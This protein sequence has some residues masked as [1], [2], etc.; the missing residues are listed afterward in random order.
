MKLGSTINL[1]ILFQALCLIFSSVTPVGAQVQVWGTS[2]SG[3]E[4]E[5]GS[6]YSVFEDGSEFTIKSS[7]NKS[8]D[9]TNPR[10]TVTIASDGS[11]YGISSAGGANNAGTIFRY[12]EGEF[13]VLHQLDFNI[14]GGNASTDLVW[15]DPLTF[16]GATLNGGANGGGVLFEYSLISGLTILHNFEGSSG[17]NSRGGLAIDGDII[18][19]TCSNG[20]LFGSG[21]VWSFNSGNYNVLHNFD[22]DDSGGN[23]EGGVILAND[24][25][26]YGTTRFGGSENQGT[27]FRIGVDGTNFETLHNL[28]LQ[29]PEGRFPRSRLVEASPGVFLGTCSD[30]GSSGA[31]VV[32]SI[33]SDGVYNVLKSLSSP[34]DGGFPK[35]GLSKEIDGRFYGVCE[36]GGA[37]GFGTLFSIE[38]DGNFTKIHDLEYVQDGANP[39]SSLAISGS[40]IYGVT[41]TGGANNF[42]TLIK[43]NENEQIEKLHDFSV[44]L[45]GSDPEGLVFHDGAF[46]GVS[47]DGGDF[48]EGIFYTIG[49]DGVRTK[50][51]DFDPVLEGRNPNGDIYYSDITDLF[52]GTFR[53]GGLTGFGAIFSIDAQGEIVILHS[54]Q[55][56]EQG[57]LPASSPY[58]HSNGSLF[59]TTRSGGS[60]GDG[61]L[62]S[63][64]TDGNYNVLHNFL[65]FFDG[66]KPGSRLV[67]GP[68]GNLYGLCSEGGGANGGSLFMYN[69][70]TNVLSVLHNFN[71]ALDGGNPI[72]A[73]LLH[74]DGKFYGTTQEGADGD[75]S[76]FSFSTSDGFE[77]LHSFDS[78]NDGSSAQG[79][80]QEGLDGSVFGICSEGGAN[81]SGTCFKYGGIDGFEV[82]HSFDSFD[83]PNPSGPIALFFP[84]CLE[85]GDCVSSDP[86][87]IGVCNFGICEE[88]P[89]NPAFNPLQIGVCEV[90]LDTYTLTLQVS[91]DLSPGGTFTIAD[92]TFNLIDGLTNY[93]FVLEGLPANGEPINL[94]YAFNET[95]CSGTT[96]VLGTA[97]PACPP[98]LTTF[99]VDVGD[100]EVS[101]EGIFLGGSF[102][103][104]TP[105]EIPMMDMGDGIWTVS[106]EVGSGTYEFNFFNGPAL[107]DAEY[108]IGECAD[109]GKRI[110]VVE[111]EPQTLEFCWGICGSN[112]S[113]GLFA[114]NRP[115]DQKILPYP[116]PI[117]VGGYLTIEV[118]DDFNA[119][120]FDVIS[121]NGTIIVQGSIQN[122]LFRIHTAGFRPGL[123]TVILR[124]ART[125]SI[126]RGRFIVN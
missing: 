122:T 83:N 44:P 28:D 18:Y 110:L 4:D 35:S 116:N 26:L 14:E 60:F 64:D 49:L 10:S 65:G 95:G 113:L 103:G 104:W 23:P 43:I 106:T 8:I 51:H 74:S 111:D 54:F 59:G 108:V 55:G 92:E 53:T 115:L 20:G 31:G 67:E 45:N 58:L 3:G 56:D 101:A 91:M 22:N 38:E 80:L 77:L 69:I 6:V 98:V 87:S 105:S 52:Y 12:S 118:P 70:Q 125:G 85:D 62:Y 37:N 102:Q 11:I 89:I 50:L 126:A 71:S 120:T 119:H 88:V 99:S 75:G 81:N 32:F 97:P 25:N 39:Q 41:V 109:N 24:G 124:E 79:N 27:I 15:I 40:S 96:G 29:T 61:L 123:Y 76:I 82:V 68:D 48:N 47:T 42:G 1:L 63:I 2:S 66:E 72:G 117:Q 7:F 112:C 90:G 114:S 33:T 93:Q 17:S 57:E 34:S 100:L 13:E 86:C 94:N 5:R 21:C 30:G 9:G 73:L 16:V 84:E 78:F 107:F 46:F 36:F 121:A 19:G